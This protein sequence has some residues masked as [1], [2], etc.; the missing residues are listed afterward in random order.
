MI[1]KWFVVLWERAMNLAGPWT[2]TIHGKGG[3]VTK[4]SLEEWG[5][6]K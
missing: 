1:P 2:L 5:T 4:F 6:P 3:A